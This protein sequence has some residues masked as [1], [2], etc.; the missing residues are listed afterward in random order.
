MDKRLLLPIRILHDFTS[1]LDDLGISYMLSGS[2]AMMHYSVYRMTADIDLILEITQNDCRRLI[3]ALEPDYYVPHD[4]MR[5]AIDTHRMFNAIHIRTAYK[6]DCVIKKETEFQRRSFA[7]RELV[8]FNGKGVWIIGK[9]DL[10]LSK[11]SWAKDTNSE[12]QLRD[13]RNLL[14]TGF[15]SEYLNWWVNKLEVGHLLQK[16]LEDL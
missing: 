15:D 9:E 11:L 1:R 12:M 4:A 14:M 2:M 16:C 8:E 5:R 13:I 7:N 6:V 3:N 10:I